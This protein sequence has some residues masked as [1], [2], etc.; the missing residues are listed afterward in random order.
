MFRCLVNRTKLFEIMS[1]MKSEG[2][3]PTIVIYNII[4]QVL[5]RFKKTDEVLSLYYLVK[6]DKSYR[7][8]HLFYATVINGCV[9]NKK[10][11]KA[12]EIL[13]ESIKDGVKLN[14]DIYNNVLEYL[15]ANTFMKTQ[16]RLN[17]CTV[18]CKA[19]KDKDY[20]INLD[21]YNRLMKLMYKPTESNFKKENGI[22]KKK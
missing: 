13:M 7:I 21:L 20:Q 14:E 18:I 9:F 17:N 5:N 6:K 11:E 4:F 15:L 3:K 1:E 10:L 8:D 22:K 19:L 16:E 12:I 2:I